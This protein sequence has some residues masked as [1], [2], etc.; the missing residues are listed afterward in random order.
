MGMEVSSVSTQV[1]TSSTTSV[2]T[3]PKAVKGKENAEA[4][5]TYEKSEP[6]V[7]SA[8]YSINKMS[9]EERANLVSKLKEEQNAR[10]AQ[11]MNLVSDMLGKQGKTFAIAN[12]KWKFLASGDYEVDAATKAQ[13]QADIAEDGYY[14]VK[15]TS[16]RLFDFASALAGDDVESMKK[17]QQAVKKGYDMAQAT[18]GGALP[19]I[20]QKTLEATN[21]LFDDYYASKENE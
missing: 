3:E 1:S 21:K 12:D 4:A 10:E 14:G 18:W 11:L 2:K 7:K 15:Q 6:S 20:C 13:A 17:M 16:Q 9:K 8:T 19:E 5:A